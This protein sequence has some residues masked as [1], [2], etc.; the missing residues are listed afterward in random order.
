MMNMNRR[1]FLQNTISALYFQEQLP[2]FSE[3]FRKRKIGLQL[4]TV[5]NEM[6][7]SPEKTLAA[8]SKIGYGYV[9]SSAYFNG[10]I[11][12]LKPKDFQ[13]LLFN[14]GL[15]MPSGFIATGQED[16]SMKGTLIN[17]LELAIEDAIKMGQTYIGISWLAPFERKTIDD[18]KVLA[19]KFNK[20]GEMCK[21]FG[22]QFFYH[23][24][25][26]EF[27]PIHSVVPYDLLLRECDDELVKM[28]LDLYWITKAGK[29]A[30][31]YFK[32][33]PQRF[34]LW[35]IKDMTSDDSQSFT[36]V[37]KGR[38]NFGQ[39]FDSQKEAGLKY[40]FVEQD[41]CSPKQPLESIKIS[42]DY[43]NNKSFIKK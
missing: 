37:G 18:Y 33:N 8:I 9:E 24:H 17:Q 12:D 26:F 39:I 16:P 42:F 11:Y 7:A 38:I 20:A 34:P 6:Q 35:H 19:E 43:L 27:S 30:Q 14:E 29:K 15:E 23:N 2:Q 40:F 28:E 31:E 4:Y 41:N 25:D 3:I 22:I 1:S 13:R 5:R 32:K 36:E 21:K 10:K